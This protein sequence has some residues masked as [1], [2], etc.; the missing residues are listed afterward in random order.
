MGC[1]H[2]VYMT[3]CK[4]A[5]LITTQ[6]PISLTGSN[7]YVWFR[8]RN[9][10]DDTYTRNRFRVNVLMM[11]RSRKKNNMKSSLL[12]VP[13]AQKSKVRTFVTTT[14]WDKFEI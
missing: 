6:L 11:F 10:P 9:T 8:L 1:N 14:P 12:P 3:V 2:T 13:S 4:G 7:M 5:T